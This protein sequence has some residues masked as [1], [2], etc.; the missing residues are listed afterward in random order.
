MELSRLLQWHALIGT[1]TG[2]GY[3]RSTE[4]S[5]VAGT[6]YIMCSHCMSD[7]GI[8]WHDVWHIG[9]IISV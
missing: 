6:T 1:S 4:C 9:I 2:K 8:L 3:D 7:E 5:P